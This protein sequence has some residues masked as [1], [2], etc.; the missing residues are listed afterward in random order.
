MLKEKV[1]E[2]VNG[3]NP[4]EIM[5]EDFY[6][7]TLRPHLKEM[8]AKVKF[9]YVLWKAIEKTINEADGFAANK[10]YD[11]LS[12]SFDVL[13]SVLLNPKS[14]YMKTAR[15][16]HASEED[17]A[18]V[19]KLAEYLSDIIMIIKYSKTEE[20]SEVQKKERLGYDTAKK[21]NII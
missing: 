14:Q 3:L 18:S 16:L 10:K 9:D 2:T 19:K 6:F 20:T 5:P 1:T 21:Q 4:L 11:F 7:D 13:S 17:Q 15:F 12:E 8:Y